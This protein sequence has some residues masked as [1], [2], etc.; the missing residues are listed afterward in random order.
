MEEDNNGRD[1]EE[2]ESGGS[3][4]WS[5]FEAIVMPTGYFTWDKALL[6]VKELTHTIIGPKILF[7][8]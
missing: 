4:S 5:M 7:N 6:A 2:E 1:E 3:D 8:F